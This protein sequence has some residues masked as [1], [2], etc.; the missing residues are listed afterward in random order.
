MHRAFPIR[1]DCKLPIS[2]L[3]IAEDV[4]AAS[5]RRRTR[6]PGP[7]RPGLTCVRRSSSHVI[8]ATTNT[9]GGATTSARG[10]RGP[11]SCRRCR[12]G[13]TAGRPRRRRRSAPPSVKKAHPK[14]VRHG[15]SR[16]RSR[17]SWRA[18]SRS[19]R[20]SRNGPRREHGEDDAREGDAAPEGVG[21]ERVA[22]DPDLERRHEPQAADEPAEVPVGLGAVRRA[23]ELVGAPL[24]DRV[25]LH[26]AAEQRRARPPPRRAGPASAARSPATSASRRRCPRAA[27][28]RRTGCACG[29]RRAPGARRSAAAMTAGRTKTCRM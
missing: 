3:P 27:R 19:R 23:V 1:G 24:P 15:W 20:G 5:S 13:R 12:T 2:S 16:G 29:A 18:R 21:H 8:F 6:L 10:R 7:P 22:E 25:D 28:A 26:E 11:G 4:E 14:A 17:R 9:T